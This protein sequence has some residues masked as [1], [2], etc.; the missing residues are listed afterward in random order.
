MPSP[1]LMIILGAVAGLAG[2]LAF[3]RFPRYRKHIVIGGVLAA[4]AAA[5]VTWYTLFR[6]DDPAFVADKEQAEQKQE[7]LDALFDDGGFDDFE[8]APAPAA[9]APPTP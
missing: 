2:A 4:G 7:Q 6:I 9:S 8:A 1:D 5:F 3:W